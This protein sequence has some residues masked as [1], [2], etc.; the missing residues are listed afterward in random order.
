LSFLFNRERQLGEN[1]LLVTLLK[2]KR[3]EGGGFKPDQNSR[4]HR[5]KPKSKQIGNSNGTDF[6]LTS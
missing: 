2:K 3:G 6:V 5:K 4:G 1:L